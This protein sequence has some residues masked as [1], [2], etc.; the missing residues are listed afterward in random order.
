MN[1]QPGAK[2]PFEQLVT[3]FEY[4]F[5]ELTDDVIDG[6]AP[7]PSDEQMTAMNLAWAETLAAARWTPGRWAKALER[8]TRCAA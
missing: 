6:I 3:A 1:Q 5:A 4:L 7:A 8:E 2:W